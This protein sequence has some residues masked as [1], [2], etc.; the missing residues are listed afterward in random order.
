M[1]AHHPAVRPHVN[2]AGIICGGTAAWSSTTAA[3][4]S[5][6]VWSTR[7]G[8]RALSSASAAS[9]SATA[10]SYRGA[11]SRC[12]VAR[13]TAARGS[14]ARYTRCPNPMSRSPRSRR[15]FTNRSARPAFSTASSM[16]STR[17]GAPPW[18]GPDMA[19]TAPDTAAAKGLPSQGRAG[20]HP[21]QSV[22]QFAPRSPSHVVEHVAELRG[23]L[24]EAPRRRRPCCR[25]PTEGSRC[26]G[27]PE[28]PSMT[29]S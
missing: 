8:R 13:R 27:T 22:N 23:R 9:S 11:P 19:P 1:W 28:T 16:G 25:L 4:N 29:Q 20:V 18:R 24:P 21:R 15:F 5:T 12:A 17:A 3:Q 14:S 10:T 2:N 6:F 26:T 7:S